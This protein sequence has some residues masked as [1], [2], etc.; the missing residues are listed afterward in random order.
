MSSLPTL[1]FGISLTNAKL[2][3]VDQRASFGAR[4]ARSSS[5]VG[6]SPARA[7]TQA[8]GRSTHFS[9]GR[10]IT[11]ASATFGCCASRSSSSTDEIHSPP[12]LITSLVRSRITM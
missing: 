5:A 2:S 11:A 9:S 7:T 6:A 12:D 4:N 3:G 10:A 8:S 1:V